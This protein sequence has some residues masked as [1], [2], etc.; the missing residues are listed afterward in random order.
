MRFSKKE[1]FS[2]QRTKNIIKSSWREAKNML[3]IFPKAHTHIQQGSGI[4]Q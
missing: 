1:N 3:Y 4:Q 2:A